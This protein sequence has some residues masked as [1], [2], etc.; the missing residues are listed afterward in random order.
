MERSYAGQ[1]NLVL[2]YL[3]KYAELRNRMF[4]RRENCWKMKSGDF[5][6]AEKMRKRKERTCAFRCRRQRRG[7]LTAIRPRCRNSFQR[8]GSHTADE[9]YRGNSSD[10]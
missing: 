5:S 10:L 4:F 6:T 8:C 9:I 2:Q 7:E 1:W 3:R